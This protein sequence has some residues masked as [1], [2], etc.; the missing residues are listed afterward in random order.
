VHELD[1]FGKLRHYGKYRSFPDIMYQ[2]PGYAKFK[3]VSVKNCQK[4]CNADKKCKAFSYRHKKQSCYLA[5]AG[6]HYDPDFVYY[7]RRGM[8]PR[9]SAMDE[10]DRQ[11]QLRVDEKA[12]KKAKRKRL[13][14]SISE[15]EDKN[16]RTANEMENKGSRREMETKDAEK[17]HAIKRLAREKALEAHDKRL[18]A[19]KTE[20]NEGYFK[21]KGVAA[22][23]KVK[24]KD[25][26]KLKAREVED[27]DKRKLQMK[28]AKN[29]KKHEESKMKKERHAAMQRLLKAKEKVTKLKNED[30]ELEIDKEERILDTAKNLALDKS[31]ATEDAKEHEKETKYRVLDRK[32]QDIS[33]MKHK[34]EIAKMSHKQEKKL[35]NHLKK[36]TENK[37]YDSDKPIRFE[38]ATNTSAPVVMPQEEELGDARGDVSPS[39]ALSDGESIPGDVELPAPTALSDEAS[40]RDSIPGD[41]ELPAPTALSDS[42]EGQNENAQDYA[43]DESEYEQDDNQISVN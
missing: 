19:M 31:E 15:R 14:A 3:Q 28:E 38:I 22:E 30:K 12:A 5:D 16:Q 33:E 25:I 40:G 36:M 29:M 32:K 10:E 9:P 26:K 39:T 41:V 1:A 13:V 21:A 42:L 43:Q 34:V 24:E 37:E 7:E 20:Y 2:E 8:K 35:L 17:K 4:H 11:D 18:A 27:K 6:I 23:K